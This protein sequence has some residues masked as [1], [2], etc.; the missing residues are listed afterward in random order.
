MR[1]LFTALALF[2]VSLV[3]AAADDAVQVGRLNCLVEGGFGL[4]IGSSKDMSCTFHREDG[5]TETYTGNIKKLGLDIGV[6]E[7]T[8]IVWLVFNAGDA[9]YAS[10]ALSG[11]YVGASGEATVGVG[12]GANWLIGGGRDSFMLQPWSVQGQTGLN[13]SVAFTGLTIN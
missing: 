10:G 2:L 6:T 1:I 7:R 13:L 3:P 12:V 9:P 4:I 11:T 8:R 5:T